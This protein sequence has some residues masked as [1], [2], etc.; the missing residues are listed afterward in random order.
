MVPAD[1]HEAEL[2]DALLADP[3][4]PHLFPNYVVHITPGPVTCDAG[5][6]ASIPYVC[7]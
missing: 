2:I 7:G 5:S 3:K 6:L 1:D 4:L